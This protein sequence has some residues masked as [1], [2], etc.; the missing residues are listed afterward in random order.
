MAWILAIWDHL[1]LNHCWVIWGV[2]GPVKDFGSFPTFPPH[3]DTQPASPHNH[4][5]PRTGSHSWPVGR[6]RCRSRIDD[7]LSVTKIKDCSAT[8]LLGVQLTCM[9]MVTHVSWCASHS[10]GSMSH[11]GIGNP[12]RTRNWSSMVVSVKNCSNL[13]FLRMMDSFSWYRGLS[14]VAHNFST[15]PNPH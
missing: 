13:M 10:T 5:V 2:K 8:S 15:D 7:A 1:N 11:C 3:T 12:C 6:N 9:V 14:E 4:L